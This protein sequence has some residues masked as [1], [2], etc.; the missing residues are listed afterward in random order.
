MKPRCTPRRV[1]DSDAGRTDA[2]PG[3]AG[4]TVTGRV[5]HESNFFWRVCTLAYG[6]GEQ[7][8]G[9]TAWGGLANGSR[10]AKDTLGRGGPDQERSLAARENDSLP[11]RRL[12]AGCA[13]HIL[14]PTRLPEKPPA[15]DGHGGGRQARPQQGASRVG[16]ASLPTRRRRP[17]FERA[18]RGSG[19][20]PTP[21]SRPAPPPHPPLL[22]PPVRLWFAAA[23]A[24]PR[25]LLAPTPSR[26]IPPARHG[27]V[28]GTSGS[29]VATGAATTAPTRGHP[30]SGRCGRSRGGG[31]SRRHG[32]GKAR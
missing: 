14:H 21:P 22:L 23:R 19:G 26:N 12:G 8:G 5:T 17:V 30:R 24:H 16:G 31:S 7:R 27:A 4:S 20:R 13:R 32:G 2:A 10:K 18:H 28:T 29:A 9:S 11:P 3:W 15:A 1:V 25:P 6:Q